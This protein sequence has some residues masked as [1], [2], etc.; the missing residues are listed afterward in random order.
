MHAHVMLAKSFSVGLDTN[1]ENH[2]L[3]FFGFFA[4]NPNIVS[5]STYTVRRPGRARASPFLLALDPGPAR[6][7]HPLLALA[8]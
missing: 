3:F 2:G 1:I 7:G 8:R 4:V 5:C 6:S